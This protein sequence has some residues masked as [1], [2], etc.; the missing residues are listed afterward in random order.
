MDEASLYA[1]LCRP[2]G[3]NAALDVFAMEPLPAD[4]PLWTVPDDR[5]LISS[6]N[7]DLTDDYFVLGW[8][9][10]ENNLARFLKGEGMAT[11]V[12]RE[13]GY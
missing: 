9:I 5:I 2:D 1:A 13:H 6:H 4:S 7:A 3:I 11:P 8:N 10:F 12:D